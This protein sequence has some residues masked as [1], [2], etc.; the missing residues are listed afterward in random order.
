MTDLLLPARNAQRIQRAADFK[1]STLDVDN[2]Y[3][4]FSRNYLAH[5]DPVVES[6]PSQLRLS[7]STSLSLQVRIEVK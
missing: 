1:E 6:R 2:I 7:A 3:V 5:V 4:T